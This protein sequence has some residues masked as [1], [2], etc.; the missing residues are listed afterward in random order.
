MVA[1]VQEPLVEELK[2]LEMLEGR[3]AQTVDEIDG[4]IGAAMKELE[5]MQAELVVG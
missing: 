4:E 3:Y 5:A 2:V 1:L